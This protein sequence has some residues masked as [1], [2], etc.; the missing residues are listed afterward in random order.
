MNAAAPLPRLPYVLLL[1][2]SLVSFGGPFVIFAAL[3]GGDSTGWPPDRAW[4]WAV[5]AVVMVLFLGLF[6]ACVS[7]RLWFRPAAHAG[8]GKPAGGQSHT[9]ESSAGDG[10]LDRQRTPWETRR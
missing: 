8:P 5:I 10:S 3:R 4:E 9:F 7:I 6:A 2:M 1:L